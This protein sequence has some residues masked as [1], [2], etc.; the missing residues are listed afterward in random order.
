MKKCRIKK[1]NFTYEEILEIQKNGGLKAI[2]EEKS[3]EG[4][5]EIIKKQRLPN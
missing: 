1:I 4:I 2:T 3:Y 5:K